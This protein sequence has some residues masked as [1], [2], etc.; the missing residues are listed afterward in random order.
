M[1][2]KRDDGPGLFD[3]PAGIKAK[4]EGIA[5]AV[6]NRPQIVEIAKAVSEDVARADPDR[7]A[8]MDR[9]QLALAEMGFSPSAL[10]PAAGGVFLCRKKWEFTGKRIL[11][12]RKKNH[13]RELKVWRLK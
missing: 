1:R 10:G 8:D 11:S 9:V 6:S 13:A 2:K 5:L 4:E 12:K 7:E 3:L